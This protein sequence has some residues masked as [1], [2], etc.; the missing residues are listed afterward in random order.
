MLI[1]PH[2]TDASVIASRTMNL[3]LGDLPVNSPV[4][5]FI[6]PDDVIVACPFSTEI[7]AFSSFYETLKPMLLYEW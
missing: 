6:A 7:L 4:L 5:I 2:Q 1:S 3:S